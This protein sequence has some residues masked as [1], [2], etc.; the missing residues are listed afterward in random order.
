[1]KDLYIL[2]SD[3]VTLFPSITA[4]KT[5]RVAR[6]QAIKSTMKIEGMDYKE[7]ARYALLGERDGLTSGVE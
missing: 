1:M 2:G 3:V 4:V 5:G 7:M 6:E